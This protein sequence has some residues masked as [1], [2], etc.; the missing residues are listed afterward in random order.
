MSNKPKLLVVDDNDVLRKMIKEGLHDNYIVNEAADGKSALL[1]IEKEEYDVIL[2]D[3]EMPVMNGFEFLTAKQKKQPYIPVVVLSAH[4][5][6]QPVLKAIRL[7]AMDFISKPFEFSDLIYVLDKAIQRKYLNISHQSIKKYISKSLHIII[8]GDEKFF[9]AVLE[10]LD[11]LIRSSGVENDH[12]AMLNIA[13]LEALK[14]AYIHGNKK[15]LK[16][17]IYFDAEISKMKITVKIKDEG[18]GFDFKNVLTAIKDNL[19]SRKERGL[20]LM[21]FNVDKLEFNKVGNKVTLIKNI[22]Y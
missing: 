19:Q 14:N 13:V 7:G 16:K 20:V 10:E 11:M 2:L 21:E 9:A 4:D 1:K 12:I 17:K 22:K 5:T 15:D 18:E 6:S 3:L 8:P